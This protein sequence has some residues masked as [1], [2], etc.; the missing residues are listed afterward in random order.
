MHDDTPARSTPA[1]APT[2]TGRLRAT[3]ARLA[4]EATD[5]ELTAAEL[6]AA[7]GTPF[8][9]LGVGSLAQLRLLDAVESRYEVFFDLAGPVGFPPSLEALADHLATEHG[10]IEHP[11]TGHTEPGRSAATAEGPA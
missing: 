11:V 9:V 2:P 8:V 5:G 4:A 1:G 10:V 3:L 6:L 7:A